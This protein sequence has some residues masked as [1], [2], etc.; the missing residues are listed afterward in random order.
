MACVVS[1]QRP[2]RLA[3]TGPGRPAASRRTKIIVS[4]AVTVADVSTDVGYLQQLRE[5][6]M[7]LHTKEQLGHKAKKG[8]KKKRPEP[9]LVGYVR[10]LQESKI[11][12]DCLERTITDSEDPNLAP[13][14]S[15]GLERGPALE[16]DLRWF[17]EAK[18]I[19]PL[20]E[21]EDGPGAKYAQLLANLADED[22]P[23]FLCHYYNIVFAHNA[24]GMMIGK[25]MA[26]KLLDGETLEFYKYDGDVKELC[27]VV[28]S[29]LEGVAAQW[30]E[31][32]RD[33]SINE[34]KNTFQYAGSLMRC[35]TQ[36]E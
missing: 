27:A 36:S 2:S 5:A 35:L 6:A 16:K 33:R 8:D 24:G 9:T 34:T 1:C 32:E 13:F 31:E 12:W 20:P 26:K 29:D 15:T 4:R 3:R 30:S 7:A 28:K 22:V 17:Q 11:V 21:Q 14:K 23:A 18:E 10:F 19:G 25:M